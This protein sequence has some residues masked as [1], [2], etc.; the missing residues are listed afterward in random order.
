MREART[1]VLRLGNAERSGLTKTVKATYKA[2]KA[3]CKTVKAKHKT[4][5]A[6][7]KTDTA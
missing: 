3:T 5:K 7:Y 1:I 6:I 4:V 2:V